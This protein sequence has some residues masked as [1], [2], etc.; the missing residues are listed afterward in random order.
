MEEYYN[1]LKEA[2][3]FRNENAPAIKE[4]EDKLSNNLNR[5]FEINNEVFSMDKESVEYGILMKEKEIL[6]KESDDLK[7][8]KEELETD[9]Y[10]KMASIKNKLESDI[11]AKTESLEKNEK[12]NISE[13]QTRLETA[14]KHLAELQDVSLKSKAVE[15]EIEITQKSIENIQK[16]IDE[17]NKNSIAM[18]KE[19]SA[20]KKLNEQITYNKYDELEEL[21]SKNAKSKTKPEPQPEPE[22]EPQPQP[23]PEPEPEPK[24]EPEPQPQPE[25]EP[26]PEPQPQS[27]PEPEPEQQPEKE[28]PNLGK[29][30]GEI[31]LDIAREEN[32]DIKRITCEV[33]LGKYIVE[34]N[35]GVTE[36]VDASVLNKKQVKDIF[37]IYGIDKKANIDPNII[38]I[39]LKYDDR[40]KNTTSNPKEN[41][42]EYV[43]K[44]NNKFEVVYSD[45]LSN[46]HGKIMLGKEPLEDTSVGYLSNSE[47][48]QDA[49]VRPL[50]RREKRFLR[51]LALKQEEHENTYVI[52][53]KRNIFKKAWDGILSYMDIEPKFLPEVTKGNQRL[54]EILTSRR[55]DEISKEINSKITAGMEERLTKYMKDEDVVKYEEKV[56]ERKRRNEFVSQYRNVLQ[57]PNL[58]ARESVNKEIEDKAKEGNKEKMN[59][60]YLK[61]KEMIDKKIEDEKASRNDDDEVR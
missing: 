28:Q 59:D 23:E 41:V 10:K 24:P 36:T 30:Y 48:K 43:K 56:E 7:V 19:I 29:T 22:P 58:D 21:V 40:V 20:L 51:K 49:P 44:P 47:M 39:L 53:D 55:N 46:R 27:E 2:F 61:T 1:E 11:K 8:K 13:A 32:K 54:E 57:N 26:E 34:L 15:E 38:S 14:K 9:F 45:K 50:K 52:M 42:M 4:I 60:P 6:E 37:N 16:R 31:D 17:I 5:G 3:D 12:E 33:G 25:P 35:N 18:L